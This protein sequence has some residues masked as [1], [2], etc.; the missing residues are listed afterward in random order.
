[1][2]TLSQPLLDYFRHE[3]EMRLGFPAGAGNSELRAA[4]AA[5]QRLDSGTFGVCGDCGKPMPLMEL[6]AD[7][8][9]VRCA[10][11]AMTPEERAGQP[12]RTEIKQ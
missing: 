3:L 12:L 1:M 7:P 10:A 4:H 2:S 9:A 5:L 6:L 8:A 11:C